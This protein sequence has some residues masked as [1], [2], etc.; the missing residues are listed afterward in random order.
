MLNAVVNLA[1]L[2]A[3][4]KFSNYNCND[5]DVEKMK[6][7]SKLRGLWLLNKHCGTNATVRA[8]SIVQKTGVGYN[9]VLN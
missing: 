3:A 8:N 9:L 1:R 4:L 2:Q 6:E 7:Q 5:V